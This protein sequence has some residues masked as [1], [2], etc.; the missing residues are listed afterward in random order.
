M[1]LYVP[2]F[3]PYLLLFEWVFLFY[4]KVQTYFRQRIREYFLILWYFISDMCMKLSSFVSLHDFL[5][6]HKK[7][8][9]KIPAIAFPRTVSHLIQIRQHSIQLHP[10]RSTF[11]QAF[12][13]LL[14]DSD[15]IT[16][17]P[18]YPIQ[19]FCSP[20]CLLWENRTVIRCALFIQSIKQ[21]HKEKRHFLVV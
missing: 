10:H 1:Y 11:H 18:P 20:S 17:T 16:F 19:S 15:L 9:V 3:Y 8:T 14:A 21:C 13:Q 7:E 4:Y 12:R 2:V 5:L 6:K